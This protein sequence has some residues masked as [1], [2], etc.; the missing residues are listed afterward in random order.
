[1][2]SASVMI[3]PHQRVAHHTPAKGCFSALG[4][5]DEYRGTGG[6]EIGERLSRGKVGQSRAEFTWLLTKR[7]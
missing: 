5:G 1:M 3:L 2:T 7:H 4:G 6:S